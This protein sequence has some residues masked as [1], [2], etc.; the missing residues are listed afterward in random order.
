[1][2]CLP[3]FIKWCEQKEITHSDLAIRMPE[4]GLTL[5]TTKAHEEGEIIASVPH[6][7]LLCIDQAGQIELLR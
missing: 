7:T 2:N 1:M 4:H 6:S 5:V 3:A